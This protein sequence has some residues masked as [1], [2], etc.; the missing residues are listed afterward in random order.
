[1]KKLLF[2]LMLLV[3]ISASAQT[4]KIKHNVIKAKIENIMSNP[5]DFADSVFTYAEEH[6][7]VKVKFFCR[8]LKVAEYDT[9]KEFDI[10]TNINDLKSKIKHKLD[11][12]KYNNNRYNT[13]YPPSLPHGISHCRGSITIDGITHYYN[14]TIRY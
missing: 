14:S 1:M 3:S 10:Q 13:I 5:D 8:L 2:I 12:N 6:K 11:Y 9:S 4:F 7:V